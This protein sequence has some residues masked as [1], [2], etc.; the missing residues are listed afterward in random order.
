MRKSDKVIY[1]IIGVIVG[2]IILSG[3]VAI[4]I[5]AY[6]FFGPTPKKR[7]QELYNYYNDDSVYQMRTGEI[8]VWSYNNS[9]TYSVSFLSSETYNPSYRLLYSNSKILKDSGFLELCEIKEQDNYKTIH[10]YSGPVTV[11]VCSS[12]GEH[13]GYNP[14]AVG[15]S[16][17][18]T[19]YLDFETG[20][21][22]LLHYIQYEMH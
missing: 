21:A 1:S 17:G 8:E 6:S 16:V 13:T 12:G 14:T 3:I 20:K 4:I 18:D 5:C 11:I 7:R 19:V 2:G 10:S 15:L 9:S 22:N